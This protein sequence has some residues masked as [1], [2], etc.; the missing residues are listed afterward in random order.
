M[1]RFQSPA[2][3]VSIVENELRRGPVAVVLEKSMSYSRSFR[4]PGENDIYR[5][6]RNQLLQAE[7]DLRRRVE[8]VAALRRQLP[9][10]GEIPE[11]YVFEEGVAD[12]S[13]TQKDRI[14]VTST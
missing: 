4:F 2:K 5:R 1:R 14:S 3:A 12:L 7:I 13:D 6:A 11:N 8:E 9:M 10:G